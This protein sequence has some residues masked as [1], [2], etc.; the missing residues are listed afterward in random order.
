MNVFL[1]QLQAMS[2]KIVGFGRL[3]GYGF[4]RLWCYG[5]LFTRSRSPQVKVGF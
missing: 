3:W 5:F 2:R 4:G 1:K